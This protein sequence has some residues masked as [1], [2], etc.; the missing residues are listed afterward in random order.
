MEAGLLSALICVHLRLMLTVS[1]LLRDCL[2]ADES[3]RMKALTL[4]RGLCYGQM[5][6]LA[7][8]F[9]VET[10]ED[11]RVWPEATSSFYL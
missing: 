1:R 11:L 4:F 3:A 5:F 7:L 9:S 2:G 8:I 10:K 6:V